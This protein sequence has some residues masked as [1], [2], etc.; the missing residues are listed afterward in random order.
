MKTNLR[1]KAG[2]DLL[3]CSHYLSEIAK[4]MSHRLLSLFG[5]QTMLSGLCLALENGDNDIE[6]RPAGQVYLVPL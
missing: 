2:K 5:T 3:R 4:A 6:G 1:V